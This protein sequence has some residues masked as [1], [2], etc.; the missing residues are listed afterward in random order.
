MACKSK[1]L[2]MILVILLSTSLIS[3]FHHSNLFLSA[4]E[5][6]TIE[7]SANSVEINQSLGKANFNGNVEVSYNILK[8]RADN[9]TV[10]YVNDTEASS[11]IESISASG[12]IKITHEDIYAEGD[13]ATF[14]VQTDTIIIKGKVVLTRNSNTISGQSL[15]FDLKTGLI[16]IDGPVKTILR[17][18]GTE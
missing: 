16:E 15:K 3:S 1:Y 17:D 14:N 2:I 6:A 11:S 4:K 8:L 10:I 12:N 18:E 5:K 13:S 7:L 9:V